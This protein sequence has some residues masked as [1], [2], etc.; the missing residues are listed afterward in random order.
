MT[1][2]CTCPTDLGYFVEG[3]DCEKCG[4][5]CESCQDG[6]SC[7]K[8]KD[9]SI[10][11]VTRCITCQ[12]PGNYVSEDSCL[13]CPQFCANCD[14]RT[15]ECLECEQ[16]FKLRNDGVCSCPR[17]TFLDTKSYTCIECAANCSECINS[18]QCM[19]CDAG[20]ELSFEGLACSLKNSDEVTDA[21][22]ERNEAVVV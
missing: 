14:I 1:K 19:T 6:A 3:N 15:G 18:R 21:D 11:G 5:D 16:T 17:S 22:T 4:D 2:Q 13:R 9:N 8:C 20:F 10:F 7:K 12:I